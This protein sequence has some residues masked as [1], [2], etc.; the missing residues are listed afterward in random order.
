M[1]TAG[2]TFGSRR[3]F[4]FRQAPENDARSESPRPLAAGRALRVECA[5]AWLASA[6][7]TPEWVA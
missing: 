2:W 7:S 6:S 5:P 4:R 1:T 3:S